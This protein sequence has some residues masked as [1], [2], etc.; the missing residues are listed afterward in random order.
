MLSSAS[1]LR[2]DWGESYNPFAVWYQ[3][4]TIISSIY[5]F[6]VAVGSSTNNKFF[7]PSRLWNS[8]RASPLVHSWGSERLPHSIFLCLRFIIFFVIA[9][10]YNFPCSGYLPLRK[11]TQLYC[12][13]WCKPTLIVISVPFL[14]CGANAVFVAIVLC[15]KHLKIVGLVYTTSE[16]QDKNINS[17]PIQATACLNC[18][19]FLD[20]FWS[21]SPNHYS[22]ALRIITGRVPSHF[23]SSVPLSRN[24]SRAPVW[25]N[26][27]APS[28]IK[29]SNIFIK[30]AKQ[31]N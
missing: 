29:H 16:P 9:E 3:L 20:L 19:H 14:E 23:V 11:N 28:A 25:V 8:P 24:S 6:V 4:R 2:S 12:A 26:Y 21:L 1:S 5:G 27:N 7:C 18:V 13:K 17:K 10:H 31:N 15:N 30:E 22:S